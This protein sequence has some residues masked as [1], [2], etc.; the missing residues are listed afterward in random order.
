M[1]NKRT[2]L[3]DDTV[4][5]YIPSPGEIIRD[6]LNAR[7]WTQRDLADIMRYPVHIVNEI[8]RAEKEI[9]VKT[10][11]ELAAAFGT[12]IDYWLN[13]ERNYR[14]WSGSNRYDMSYCRWSDDCFQSD[15]YCFEGWDGFCIYVASKRHISD[16]PKPDK[17]ND[18]YGL[19]KWY[20]YHKKCM[21]WAKQA[22]TKSIGLPYD[23]EQYIFDTAIE[24]LEKL[25]E[26]REIGYRVPQHAID[27]LSEEMWNYMQYDKGGGSTLTTDG[28]NDSGHYKPNYSQPKPIN[29]LE[30]YSNEH[31]KY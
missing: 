8:I 26:L 6:E 16:R 19:G 14:I 30:K 18:E 20:Y 5:G 2:E 21:E 27:A 13:L 10:A 17:P 22:E 31:Y 1:K 29:K 15:V 23:G 25:L 24:C 28:I 3:S 11:I 4:F 9:T 12:S 7:G